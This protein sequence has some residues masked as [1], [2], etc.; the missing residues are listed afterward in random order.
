VVFFVGFFWGGGE[1]RISLGAISKSPDHQSTSEVMNMVLQLVIIF[2]EGYTTNIIKDLKSQ[3]YKK[4][5]LWEPDDFQK[6]HHRG[7]AMIT[8]R[9]I[10]G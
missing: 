1:C 5:R 10:S 3:R 2:Q 8:A 7:K 6:K 9:K 4:V